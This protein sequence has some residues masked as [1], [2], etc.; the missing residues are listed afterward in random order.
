MNLVSQ[1]EFRSFI[2]AV[3]N[4]CGIK[5]NIASWI[6]SFETFCFNGLAKIAIVAAVSGE[7]HS[8]FHENLLVLF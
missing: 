6:G 7:K 1:R 8:F 2:F 4:Y 5:F 3:S